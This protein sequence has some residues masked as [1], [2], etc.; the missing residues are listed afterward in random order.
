MALADQVNQYVSDKAP[1][2]LAKQE[3]DQRASMASFNHSQLL[4]DY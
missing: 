4:F 2:T 1:W 3:R